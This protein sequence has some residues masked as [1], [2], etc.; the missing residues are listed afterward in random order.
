MVSVIATPLE[1][2]KIYS[3]PVVAVVAFLSKLSIL[4]SGFTFIPL[5][6]A[7]LW[8]WNE[9]VLISTSVSGL[10]VPIPIFPEPEKIKEILH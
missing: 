9:S 1:Y 6:S 7:N 10:S 2:F 4:P 8:T 3:L 5:L